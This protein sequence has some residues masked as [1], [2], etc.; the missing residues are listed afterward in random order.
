MDKSPLFSIATPVFNTGRYLRECLDSVRDQTF[1]DWEVVSV[2]DGSTDDS[3]AILDEFAAA[4]GRFRAI[5]QSNSG[6]GPARNAALEAASGEWLLFLDGD[7]VLHPR[8]LERIAE[9]IARH[10]ELDAIRFGM[11][12]FDGE[13]ACVWGDAGGGRCRVCDISGDFRGAPTYNFTCIAYRRRKLGSVRFGV[14]TIG[15]DVLFLAKFMDAADSFCSIDDELYGYRIRPGSAMQSGMSLQKFL[16]KLASLKGV[17]RLYALSRK[18]VPNSFWRAL[19]NELMEA[20]PSEL[21][22]LPC[23]ERREASCAWRTTAGEL[24]EFCAKKIPLPQR[25]RMRLVVAHPGLPATL[26]CGIPYRLKRMGLH[27]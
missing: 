27:R 17:M 25:M 6:A 15:E 26:L 2:D 1:A 21:K 4:D 16:D 20:L 9:L 12:R 13:S 18:H 11:K 7:D 3:G 23:G 24:L 14:Q 8:A 19:C 22:A 10:G 5:H